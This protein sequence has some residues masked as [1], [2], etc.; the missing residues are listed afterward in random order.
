MSLLVSRQSSLGFALHVFSFFLFVIPLSFVSLG[1]TSIISVFSLLLHAVSRAPLFSGIVA[2]LLHVV[3]LS[4][5]AGIAV[6]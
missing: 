6:V 5:F 2:S 3:L 1:K 4:A